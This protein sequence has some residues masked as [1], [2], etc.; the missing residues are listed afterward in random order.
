MRCR[1]VELL[2]QTNDARIGLWRQF[3]VW[4][5][6][7]ARRRFRTRINR[8]GQ[9]WNHGEHRR[10]YDRQQRRKHDKQWRRY[11]WQHRRN[12]DE[13]WRQY[14]GQHWW[15]HDQ[16][17]RQCHREH[18]RDIGGRWGLDDLR[19][20]DHELGR[21]V[22]DREHASTLRQWRTRPR[23]NRNRLWRN[24]SG[25]PGCLQGESTQSV[26]EPVLLFELQVWRCDDPVW[27]RVPA[28]QRLRECPEQGWQGGLRLFALHAIQPGHVAGSERRRCGEWLGRERPAVP[29]CGGRTRHQYRWYRQRHDRQPALL[30]MLSIDIR[31]TL[32]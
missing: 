15:R 3:L 24:M 31:S 5:Q 13:Y 6:V 25:V 16:Q 21:L 30:R 12:H 11:H 29:L 8:R 26:S 23:R 2:L 9:G 4:R 7:G 17:W 22:R 18:R 28:A 14:H 19:W 32:Q 10:R 1:C 20:C 27:G